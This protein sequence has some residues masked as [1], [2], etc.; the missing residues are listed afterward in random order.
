MENCLFG[1][2]YDWEEFSEEYD[3]N[4][5]PENELSEDESSEDDSIEESILTMYD[6]GEEEPIVKIDE[7]ML[8]EI[9]DELNGRGSEYNNEMY[10]ISH[11]KPKYSD[12]NIGSVEITINNRNFYRKK[13]ILLNNPTDY[14]KYMFE[15]RYSFQERI[16][17]TRSMLYQRWVKIY[18]KIEND[19]YYYSLDNENYFESNAYDLDEMLSDCLRRTGYVKEPSRAKSARK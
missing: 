11:C 14:E 15:N 3:F 13:R 7:D 4:E 8:K 16:Y 9:I 6:M 18:Y 12:L 19:M 2:G 10:T 5:L 1:A 17:E